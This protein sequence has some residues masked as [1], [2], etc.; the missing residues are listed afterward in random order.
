MY[1]LPCSYYYK[2]LNTNISFADIWWCICS[3]SIGHRLVTDT[4]LRDHVNM[5]SVLWG[6][7]HG[8]PS[9][10]WD[11]LVWT[12]VMSGNSQAFYEKGFDSAGHTVKLGNQ[13]HTAQG[14][15]L[16]YRQNSHHWSPSIKLLQLLSLDV[17]ILL[18]EISFGL[19]VIFF[20]LLILLPLNCC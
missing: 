5:S 13:R 18:F 20:F 2:A 17:N 19:F 14:L 4:G 9:S 1:F 16:H 6:K 7:C 8:N 15:S 3:Q 12:K 10:S 11:F